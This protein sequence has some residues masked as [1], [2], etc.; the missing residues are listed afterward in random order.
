MT[1]RRRSKSCD[2]CSRFQENGTI[3]DGSFTSERVSMVFRRRRRRRRFFFVCLFS[4]PRFPRLR[5]RL[6]DTINEKR[7]D[8]I[9]S[10]G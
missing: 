6:N 9:G 3:Y 1:L 8:D 7:T 2:G 4:V 5:G 10:D